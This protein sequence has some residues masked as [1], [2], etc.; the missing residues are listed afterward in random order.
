MPS[1][2]PVGMMPIRRSPALIQFAIWLF[3]PCVVLTGAGSQH[4]IAQSQPTTQ[5]ASVREQ[6]G[7]APHP[8]DPEQSIDRQSQPGDV[9]IDGR[10]VLSVYQSVGSITPRDRAEKI[11]ERIVAAAKERV[12]PDS[13]ELT[14][15]PQWTEISAAGNLLLA[16]SDGDAR[17]A[18]K[19]R[20]KLAEEYVVNIRQAL[21]NYRRE[22]NIRAVFVGIGYSLL[23][24][25]VLA[26]I[27]FMVRRLRLSLRRRLQQWVADTNA[28]EEKKTA[29]QIGA[30]YAVTTLLTIGRL[31]RWLVLIALFEAYVTVILSFF[32]QTRLFSHTVTGWILSGLRSIG[33][34]ALAYL[35]NLFIVAVI[36]IIATQVSRLITLLFEEV[37]KGNLAI[38]GFYPEW[39]EPT[40]KL[41]KMLVTALVII[42]IFPYLPGSKSPTF[43]GITIFVGVLLSLGSSSVVANGIAGVILTYM[44]SFSVGDWVKIGDTVGE[45]QEKNMLVTRILTQKQETI[46]IP[47]ATVMSGSVMNYTREAKN[48]G[49]IFHTTVTIGYDASW[50][51]VHQLLIDAAMATD[52]VLHNP[53]PFVLETAL[54]DFYVSYEL[55]AHTNV[56]ARMQFIYSDL[57]QNIQDR[58]NEAGIEICS[59]HFASLRDGNTIA[60]PA[61]YISRDYTAPEFRV[62]VA[63]EDARQTTANRT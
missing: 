29:L 50:K 30:T 24:T 56:P 20:D 10:K 14:S 35:P 11:T 37:R 42:V 36:I 59:P 33:N 22:H 43:Q 27:A 52:G 32:P 21:V 48:T 19:T 63:D 25:L 3:T 61:Q 7:T 38:G 9:V 44:R 54:N 4:V 46:T 55:N 28:R 40:A 45:V 13:V 16:V 62:A 12:N 47:N 57:H 49:V 39:A 17:A 6:A 5:S 34:S 1:L 23:A 8:A 58:F 53:A 51:T 2:F 41:I 60:I 31:V 15:R 26:P 18:G